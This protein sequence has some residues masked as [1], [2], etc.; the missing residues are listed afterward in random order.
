MELN[1][2]LQELRKA[3]GMTQEELA[4]ALYVS[5]TAISKWES[6]RGTPGLESLKQI[7]AFFSVSIDDL[8]SAENV[9]TLA[10]RESEAARRNRIDFGLGLSD[11]GALLPAVLPLYPNAVGETVYAVNLLAYTN[12][13]NRLVCI[14]LFLMLILT[15][16]AEITLACL[17]KR[18]GCR[19]LTVLSFLLGIV[20][21]LFMIAARI[22]YAAAVMFL[23][24]VL[25]GTL[26]VCR[27]K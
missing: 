7:S 19:A 12:A 5:R 6:G 25:K 23:L 18:R 13:R 22:G 4:K 17:K 21:V 20:S 9:L 10:E 16:A 1:E 27:G 24:L 15:G 26:L 2:K 8:L 3:K 11:A 14:V